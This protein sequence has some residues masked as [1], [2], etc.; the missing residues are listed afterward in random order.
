MAKRL[1]DKGLKARFF[2]S[3][4]KFDPETYEYDT[5]FVS[6]D[7]SDINNFR[8][9]HTTAEMV[10]FL[11]K[12]KDVELDARVI[13]INEKKKLRSVRAIEKNTFIKAF[14]SDGKFKLRESVDTFASDED[15]TSG[16]VGNDFVPLLG[17]PFYKNLY[18]YQDYIRMHGQCFF[19]YHHDPIA[20]AI[21]QTIVD[22]TL[23]KGFRIDS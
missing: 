4:L 1:E 20:K 18:F 8:S 16:T 2:D 6:A 11:E 5:S 21:V 3:G 23:G 13:T 12:H 17:G 9:I 22:F 19:A 14:Q 15:V 10:A 7:V